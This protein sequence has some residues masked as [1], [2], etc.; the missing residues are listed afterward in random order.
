MKFKV[1]LAIATL[2]TLTFSTV[3]L[4][5]NK[6]DQQKGKKTEKDVPPTK[7]D[8]GGLGIGDGGGIIS[9]EVIRALIESANL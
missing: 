8:Q 9:S 5:A 6:T 3:S 2:A 1:F 4:G 7:K